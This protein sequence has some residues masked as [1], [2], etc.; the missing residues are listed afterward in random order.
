MKTDNFKSSLLSVLD[1]LTPTANKH[2]SAAYG[3]RMAELLIDDIIQKDNAIQLIV[4]LANKLH[5]DFKFNSVELVDKNTVSCTDDTTSR[6]SKHVVDDLTF[7]VL[8][9]LVTA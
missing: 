3:Y 9:L 5:E 2:K 7:E 8:S 6:K 1:I 4:S